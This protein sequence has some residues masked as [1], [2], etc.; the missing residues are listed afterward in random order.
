MEV[1]SMGMD[2]GVG[3]GGID[4]ISSSITIAQGTT[5]KLLIPVT[6]ADGKPVNLA[7]IEGGLCFTFGKQTGYPGDLTKRAGDGGGGSSIPESGCE[8]VT[9]PVGGLGEEYPEAENNALLVTLTAEETRITP[10]NIYIFGVWAFDEDGPALLLQGEM[11]V[12]GTVW[13]GAE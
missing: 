12:V 5:A 11:E 7:N 4:G 2:S 13:C 6:D 3:I 8:I 1:D 10:G 9:D